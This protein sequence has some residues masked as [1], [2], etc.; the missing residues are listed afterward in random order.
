M[1]HS[2]T[3][4]GCLCATLQDLGFVQKLSIFMILVDFMNLVN[5]RFRAKIE[6]FYDFGG[7]YEFSEQKVSCKS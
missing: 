4:Q 6:Y 3:S 2:F 5:R 1:A 7:F